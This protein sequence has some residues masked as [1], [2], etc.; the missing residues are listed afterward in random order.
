[1]VTHCCHVYV[2]GRCRSTFPW[3]DLPLELKEDILTTVLLLRL[4]QLAV[5]CKGFKAAYRQRQEIVEALLPLPP[6]A[7]FPSNFWDGLFF[8]L[9]SRFIG[10]FEHI[11]RDTVGVWGWWD[12]YPG[13]I[14]RCHDHDKVAVKVEASYV[15]R[16]SRWQRGAVRL[17]CVVDKS[18]LSPSVVSTEMILDC[19]D[20]PPGPPPTFGILVGLKAA[21]AARTF[22]EGLAGNNAAGVSRQGQAV[23]LERVSVVLPE[24]SSWPDGPEGDYICDA[25]TT[26]LATAGGRPSGVRIS[27][28]G[29]EGVLPWRLPCVLGGEPV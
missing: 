2:G 18:A 6:L 10:R 15:A 1:M 22:F 12:L 13:G 29:T 7:A 9:K 26:I 11:G 28:K 21:R 3:E 24:G 19:S 25:I 17:R 14:L 4:A 27:V 20:A 16:P 23:P 5:F 8:G